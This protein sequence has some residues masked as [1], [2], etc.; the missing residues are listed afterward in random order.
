MLGIL[1]MLGGAILGAAIVNVPRIALHFILGDII[2]GW[3]IDIFICIW[4]IFVMIVIL[5]NYI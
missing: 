1:M 3:K 2:D 5:L 4:T